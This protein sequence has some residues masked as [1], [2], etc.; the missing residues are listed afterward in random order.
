MVDNGGRVAGGGRR[1]GSGGTLMDA[2]VGLRSIDSNEGWDRDNCESLLCGWPCPIFIDDAVLLAEETLLIATEDDA[3]ARFS[4]RLS[5]D[6]IRRSPTRRPRLSGFFPLALL[7]LLAP[8][9]LLLLFGVFALSLPSMIFAF[10]GGCNIHCVS[11][12]C[13]G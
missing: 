10:G 6:S 7:S 9:P 13:V 1:K 8:L 12:R 4:P 3:V 2:A 5:F 11:L